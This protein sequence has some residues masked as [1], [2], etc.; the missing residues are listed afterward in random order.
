M[1]TSFA[2]ENTEDFNFYLT[3]ILQ[4]YYTKPY[5]LNIEFYKVQ[6]KPKL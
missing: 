6:K 1:K 4:Y 3:V 2:T 5:Y